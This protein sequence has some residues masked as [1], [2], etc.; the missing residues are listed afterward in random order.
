L[1]ANRVSKAAIAAATMRKNSRN[2]DVGNSIA[3]QPD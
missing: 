3:A 1:A 2:P